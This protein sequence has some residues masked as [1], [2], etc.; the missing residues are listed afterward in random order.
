V[1]NCR[2]RLAPTLLLLTGI[3]ILAAG[4]VATKASAASQS[5]EGTPAT[6]VLRGSMPDP[7][8][9]S[10]AG[11]TA[12]VLRGSPPSSGRPSAAPYACPSG[13]D[14]D[15]TFGCMFPGYA[16]SPGDWGYWPYYGFDGFFPSVSKRHRF[17][18]GFARGTSRGPAV[19]F[20]RPSH[21]GFSQGFAHVT[22]FGRR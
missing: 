12:V 17:G 20:G 2:N 21:S 5:S 1:I 14:Y 10:V 3:G 15:P 9:S 6:V 7:P 22:G 19:R 18:H 8:P 4:L 13:Y 16:E 11:G